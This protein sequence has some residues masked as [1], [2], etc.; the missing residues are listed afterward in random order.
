MDWEKELSQYL[1]GETYAADAATWYLEH[2]DFT[3]KTG[4]N[5]LGQYQGTDYK[6]Y[7]WVGVKAPDGYGITEAKGEVMRIIAD[8]YEYFGLTAVRAY[9]DNFHPG[10]LFGTNTGAKIA[11]NKIKALAPT[12]QPVIDT[13]TLTIILGIIAGL[14]LIA[15]LIYAFK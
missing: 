7:V 5:L 10:V 6:Y 11:S 12:D 1:T 15:I 9:D 13:D 8:N 2:K 14:I 4:Y 3:R